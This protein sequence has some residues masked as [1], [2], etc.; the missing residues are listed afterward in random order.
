MHIPLCFFT[1]D[2]RFDTGMNI[3]S[4]EVIRLLYAIPEGFWGVWLLHCFCCPSSVIAPYLQAKLQLLSHWFF[5]L[6]GLQ[7]CR[8]VLSPCFSAPDARLEGRMNILSSKAI[9]SLYAI[10]EGFWRV[11]CFWGHTSPFERLGRLCSLDFEIPLTSRSVVST[12][13]RTH[14]NKQKTK[15]KRKN[16]HIWL[17]SVY[18]HK[19]FSFLFPQKGFPL[20]ILV[21]PCFSTSDARLEVGMNI[22]SSEAIRS[23]YAILEG[24]SARCIF[25]TSWWMD[26]LPSSQCFHEIPLKLSESRLRGYWVLR[27]HTSSSLFVL[28]PLEKWQK[29]D[30]MTLSKP[31]KNFKIWVRGSLH[32]FSL[33]SM[34]VLCPFCPSRSSLPW[35][36]G[37]RGEEEREG[38]RGIIG[39]GRQ[40]VVEKSKGMF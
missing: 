24:F 12:S 16:K 19:N 21:R 2:T 38:R 10:L 27:L 15:K 3:L 14:E 9:C 8:T 32:T 6:Q 35:F 4:S 7:P 5:N 30:K 33:S 1:S 39:G 40:G 22:L 18:F 29:T 17:V 28:S 20:K 37:E 36:E 23:L 34:L 11:D 26:F 13:N 31:R 25:S